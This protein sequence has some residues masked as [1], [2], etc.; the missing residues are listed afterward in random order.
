MS[1]VLLP[2]FRLVVSECSGLS[3]SHLQCLYDILSP[4]SVLQES[5]VAI[6]NVSANYGAGFVVKGNL[7]VSVGHSVH[8][9]IGGAV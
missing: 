3:C 6:Q 8:R 7:Y 1:L 9:Q 4:R 2:K 5:E